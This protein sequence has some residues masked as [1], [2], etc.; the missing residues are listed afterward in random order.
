VGIRFDPARLGVVKDTRL[1]QRAVLLYD[2]DPRQR[3]VVAALFAAHYE[4]ALDLSQLALVADVAA[5]AA[6]QPT[7][8]VRERLERGDG[9]ERLAAD[10][11]EA[12]ELGVGTVPTY[13]VGGVVAVR[14]DQ[15]PAVLRAMIAEARRL[16]AA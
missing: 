3:A 2:G 8:Q 1:A 11:R 12:A 14:G 13:V 7:H 6:G 16:A 4:E 9:S 10:A 15:Q 5:H